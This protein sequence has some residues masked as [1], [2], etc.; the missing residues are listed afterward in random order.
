ADHT[1][2]LLG[3]FAVRRQVV[4]VVPVEAIDLVA[5]H[6]ALDLDGLGALQLYGVD[7]V[8]GEQ[9]VF[10]LGDLV[11]LHQLG[12]LDRPGVR[13]GG[14]H[15]DPVVGLRIDQVEVYVA[16]RIGRRVERHRTGDERELQVPLP[17]R[18]IR[19]V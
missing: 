14:D 16:G 7:L 11:A 12:A 5:G 3:E 4:G 13:V 8:V 1:K 17:G 9:D 10:A 2:G 15:L 19:H 6:E 18:T